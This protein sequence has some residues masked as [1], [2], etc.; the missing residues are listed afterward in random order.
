MGVGVFPDLVDKAVKSVNL[1]I[2]RINELVV[3]LD[4][5]VKRV[6]LFLYLILLYFKLGVVHFLLLVAHTLQ[7]GGV[8]HLAVFVYQLIPLALSPLQFVLLFLQAEYE[9]FFP[10]LV[11]Q[12]VQF[13]LQRLLPVV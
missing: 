7:V 11:L 13:V 1:V 9:A 12:C 5:V 8:S 6:N 2:Y 4:L 3:L 10:R